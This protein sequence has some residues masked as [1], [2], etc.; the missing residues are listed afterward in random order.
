M[1]VCDRVSPSPKGRGG[2]GSALLKPSVDYWCFCSSLLFGPHC[3][4]YTCVCV[5]VCVRVWT[6]LTLSWK[7]T[8]D[9]LNVFSVTATRN[10]YTALPWHT[11]TTRIYDVHIHIQCTGKYTNYQLHKSRTHQRTH[12]HTS[13]GCS[14]TGTELSERKMIKRT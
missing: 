5:Y 3:I 6:R 10:Y 2:A 4:R 1:H 8:S 9:S 13:T 11:L 7:K 14:V 12:T